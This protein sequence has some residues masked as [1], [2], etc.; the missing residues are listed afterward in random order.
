MYLLISTLPKL[1][2]QCLIL[3]TVPEA[4]EEALMNRLMTQEVHGK[5][6]V[7]LY[8]KNCA[9]PSVDQ[10]YH[11]LVALGFRQVHVYGG[12]MLEWTLLQ[13][14]FGA[15]EFPTTSVTTDLLRFQPSKRL[16]IG[17]G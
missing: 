9:D 10:K 3:H 5:T 12:G 8:G 11:Q 16:L 17:P 2:Q 4:E 14:V 15:R 1:E 13:D 7:I 6:P